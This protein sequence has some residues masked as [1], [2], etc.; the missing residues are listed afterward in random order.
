MVRANSTAE[1]VGCS[2]LERSTATRGA[3]SPFR[4]QMPSSATSAVRAERTHAETARD[5]ATKT[6]KYAR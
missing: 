6:A 1:G 2:H 4:T 5:S 3:T